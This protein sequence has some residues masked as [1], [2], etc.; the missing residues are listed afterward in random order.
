MQVVSFDVKP[1]NIMLDRSLRVAKLADMG[2]AKILNQSH[3]M[4][5]MV[6]SI[7]ESLACMP[8]AFPYDKLSS[9]HCNH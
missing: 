2:L 1:T 5:H 8:L 9:L 3:T 4:T 6:R 7:S